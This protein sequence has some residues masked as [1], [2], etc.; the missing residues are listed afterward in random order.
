VGKTDGKFVESDGT[1]VG[2]RVGG[3]LGE[4]VGMPSIGQA[5]FDFQSHVEVAGLKRKPSW[6][7]VIGSLPWE[8]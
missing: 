5:T 3:A 8:Q 1:D 6:Q 7:R 2:L 4:P